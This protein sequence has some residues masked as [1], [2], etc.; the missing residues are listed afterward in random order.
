MLEGYT[1]KRKFALYLAAIGLLFFLALIWMDF[2]ADFLTMLTA[3]VLA[4][5]LVLVGAY[6]NW[7]EGKRQTEKE[8]VIVEE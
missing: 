8:S 2:E 5:L 6:Y 4:G 1:G 3:R 7:I